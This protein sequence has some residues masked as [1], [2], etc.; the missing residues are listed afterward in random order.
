[1]SVA[2]AIHPSVHAGA[3][4]AAS[5]LSRDALNIL[6]Q[7]ISNV[8]FHISIPKQL[9]SPEW[10]Y[11]H[12]RS[13]RRRV[14]GPERTRALG[15]NH[16]PRLLYLHRTQQRVQQTKSTL[17]SSWFLPGN[18]IS[19]LYKYNV[20]ACVINSPVKEHPESTT[21]DEYRFAISG[22]NILHINR[23]ERASGLSFLTGSLKICFKKT[24]VIFVPGLWSYSLDI[25]WTRTSTLN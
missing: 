22:N 14:L 15:D 23:G 20:H 25:T 18:Y 17:H 11:P 19:Y 7:E 16:L 3:C 13:H 5:H 1:M 9:C 10:M 21:K 24:T 12:C 6:F 4:L 8:S 2:C